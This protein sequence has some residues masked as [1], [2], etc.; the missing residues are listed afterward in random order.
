[1]IKVIK[2][3]LGSIYRKATFYMFKYNLQYRKNVQ[4]DSTAKLY[5]DSENLNISNDV[6]I[7]AYNVI[8]AINS[9]HSNIKGLLKIGENTSIGEFNNIRAA[10]GSI[11]IGC[12]CLISQ[13]VTIV[14]SNH[15]ID[16]SSLIIDQGWNENKT[17]VFIEDDVWIGANSVILPGVNIGKGAIIA[18]GSIVNKDV[19]PYTIVG[20]VPARFIKSR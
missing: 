9:Q 10:G 15:N 18:A 11:T 3:I 14:A 6:V 1:M 17:G 7:G 8:Y 2:R 13:Y 16:N 19:M 4:I 5:F 20:G 12:N